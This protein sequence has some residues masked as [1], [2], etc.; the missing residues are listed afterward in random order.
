MARI[1]ME[2]FK[3]NWKGS[4]KGQKGRRKL[5]GTSEWGGLFMLA[6]SKLLW[7][8]GRAKMESP[9]AKNQGIR[10]PKRVSFLTRSAYRPANN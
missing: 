4:E 7:R 2:V 9:R 3:E 6:L 10:D 1:G 5:T 8:Y